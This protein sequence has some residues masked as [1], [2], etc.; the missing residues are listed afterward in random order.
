MVFETNFP[1]IRNATAIHSENG[2]CLII[3]REGELVRLYI[4]LS[5]SDI[6]GLSS[7]GRVDKSKV[8]PQKLFE[9]S[10]FQTDG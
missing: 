7:S 10:I 6:A 2:S 1:D 3:P 4:Q 8:T 5:D 9:V